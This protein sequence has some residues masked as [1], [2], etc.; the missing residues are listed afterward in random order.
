MKGGIRMKVDITGRGVI[1]GI[2]TLAPKYDVELNESQIRRL[3]NFSQFR[4]S[5]RKTNLLITK[6]NVD[7]FFKKPLITE[8]PTPKPVSVP[9]KKETYVTP[10]ITVEPTPV[11]EEETTIELQ[12][13]P[14]DPLPEEITEVP[15]VEV[16]SYTSERIGNVVEASPEPEEEVTD[17]VEP[18]VEE[19]VTTTETKAFGKKKKK[20][21]N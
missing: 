11:I 7:N 9:K 6:K 18:E 5:D 4:L 3:L 19:S 15:T 12:E 13:I 20:R 14:S 2:G 10:V 21:R 16:I 8:L 1:P 17:L